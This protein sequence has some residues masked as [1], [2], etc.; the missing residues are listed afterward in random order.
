MLLTKRAIL[1][2]QEILTMEHLPL[3]PN[4]LTLMVLLELL[5]P[6]IEVEII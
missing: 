4:N 6:I 3:N 2:K 1:F 5:A